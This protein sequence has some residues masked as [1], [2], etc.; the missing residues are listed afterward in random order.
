MQYGYVFISVASVTPAPVDS[1]FGR[2]GVITAALNDYLASLVDNDSTVIGATVKDALETLE[3]AIPTVPVD[4]VFGRT[5][6]ITAALNDYL[7]SQVDNDSTVIGATVKDALETLAAA[8]GV[9]FWDE[10]ESIGGTQDTTSWTPNNAA[11]NINAA[12]IPK[13]TG[14]IIGS[15]PDGL[16]AGGNARG[17]NAIDFQT[18][19]VNATEV[20]SGL[21]SA[22]LGGKNNTAAG[23]EAIVI[24][25]N[26]LIDADAD[27]CVILGGEDNSITL[28][29]LHTSIVGGLDNDTLLSDYSIILGGL[30]GT[31]VTGDFAA[32]VAGDNCSAGGDASVSLAGKDNQAFGVM[33][34]TL[35]GEFNKCNPGAD[36]STT[37]GG[38]RGLAQFKAQQVTGSE[39]AWGNTVFGNA[40]FS[41]HPMNA[42]IL[43]SD[44][45]TY[46]Y[47]LDAGAGVI[48][49]IGS[50]NKSWHIDIKMMMR[51]IVA[52]GG[53]A[54][55]DSKNIHYEVCL[56][57]TA[58]TLVIEAQGTSGGLGNA[59]MNGT[60]LLCSI[61]SGKILKIVA[62]LPT[63]AISTSEFIS[64]L[65]VTIVQCGDD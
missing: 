47:F 45:S 5:G 65:K 50:T 30:D 61:P 32:V 48:D 52:G 7:A 55:G 4:S 41:H 28:T 35:A 31:N 44:S 40:Q 20:A 2:T 63:L 22:I 60:D 19:R 53:I 18:I 14:A 8:G 6:V 21:R 42:A 62:V 59:T 11:T 64:Q 12:I 17:A 15:I 3:A 16:A 13:G 37:L 36:A 10:A 51:C 9:S 46:E 57:I 33:T 34:A 23:E 29:S 27:F 43:E 49:F 26:N 24:G 54:V 39:S 1:V 38:R 25:V 56:S 58:G